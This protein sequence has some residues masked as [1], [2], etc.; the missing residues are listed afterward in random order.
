[1][2]SLICYL[3]EITVY[4][5]YWLHRNRAATTLHQ[6][7]NSG[8]LITLT[9]T[10]FA[11]RLMQIIEICDLRIQI[12]VCFHRFF[13]NFLMTQRCPRAA[14]RLTA[15]TGCAYGASERSLRSPDR[16]QKSA[17]QKTEHLFVREDAT[18]PVIEVPEVRVAPAASSRAQA[19]ITGNG[20]RAAPQGVSNICFFS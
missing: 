3:P 14:T 6:T 12:L 8:R 17:V 11:P 19:L 5:S 7:N 13:Q 2:N 18:K 10:C 4:F 16:S 20:P 15:G 1:M 9:P